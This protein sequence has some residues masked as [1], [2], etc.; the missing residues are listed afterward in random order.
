L[1]KI[2]IVRDKLG[3]K[4]KIDL[5]RVAFVFQKKIKLFS[6][7]LLDMKRD[8]RRGDIENMVKSFFNALTFKMNRD[9]I[10]KDYPNIIR[11]CGFDEGNFIE[12]DIG[13]FSKAKD[14]EEKRSFML[15]YLRE[16]HEFF[17]RN[18]PEVFPFFEKVEREKIRCLEN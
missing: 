10:N 17:E 3:I 1:K 16:F 11:N 4:H 5:D 8:R 9:I 18:I 12:L 15:S 6:N 14:R 7:M 13:S 2:I